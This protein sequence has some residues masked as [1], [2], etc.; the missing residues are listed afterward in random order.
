MI[1]KKDILIATGGTGGHVFPAYSLARCFIKKNYN[2]KLTTDIRGFN[3]LKEYKNL[4]LIKI[5]SSPIIKKNIFKFIF[6]LSIILYSIIRSFF[7]YYLIDL[8]LY[9]A[10][11]VT[12]LFQYVLQ[13]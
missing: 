10:W 6:S 5:P 12:H 3:Y 11:V 8:Q 1:K 7:F 4:D 13:L 2:V 9:L